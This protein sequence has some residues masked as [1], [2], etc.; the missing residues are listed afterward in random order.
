MDLN[1][2]ENA[3]EDAQDAAKERLVI[4]EAQFQA[5]ATAAIEEAA[6]PVLKVQAQGIESAKAR[7][8][9]PRK[10]AS[11]SFGAA[12]PSEPVSQSEQ[13]SEAEVI[14]PLRTEG[15]LRVGDRRRAERQ[16]AAAQLPRHERWKRRL[17]S[18]AW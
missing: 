11:E 17:H 15:R 13:A 5:D 8:R 10:K 16:T 9:Q 2:N 4:P 7:S 14:K 6:I 12:T 1:L 3:P 18:A